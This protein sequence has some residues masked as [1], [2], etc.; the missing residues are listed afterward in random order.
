MVQ[1]SWIIS[2]LPAV[3]FTTISGKTHASNNLQLRAGV[4][5]VKVVP[6]SSLTKFEVYF[7]TPSP[8]MDV[9]L[10]LSGKK[11]KSWMAPNSEKRK[12]KDAVLINTTISTKSYQ[13]DFFVTMSHSDL[14]NYVYVFTDSSCPDQLWQA[15]LNGISTDVEFFFSWKKEGRRLKA[16]RSILAA[17]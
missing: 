8:V 13:I 1:Y 16:H 15:A 17:R 5:A 9:Y 7:F 12:F 10:S 3:G 4:K 2:S 14:G 11:S 6:Y